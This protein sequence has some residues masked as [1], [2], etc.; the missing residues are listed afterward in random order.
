MNKYKNLIFILL[1]ILVSFLYKL[2]ISIK[3]PPSSIHQWRQ[4]DALSITKNYFEEGMHFFEPK[5]HFQA[6]VEGK[7]VGEFPIIYYVNAAIWKITGENY[8]TVRLLNLSIV[9]LGLFFLFKLCD[10]YLNNLFYSLLIPYLIFSSPLFGYYSNNFL[11]NLPAVC[12]MFIGWYYLYKSTQENGQKSMV[13]ASILLTI[14]ILLRPTLLIGI[15]PIY[16]IVFLELIGVLKEKYLDKK[17]GFILFIPLLI[18][19]GW[20]LFSK[21]YNLKNGSIYFLLTIKPIWDAPNKLEIWNSFTEIVLPEFYHLGFI[22]LFFVM[23]LYIIFNIKKSNIYLIIILVTLF[24][25]LIIFVLLWFQNLNVHDYYLLDFYLIIPVLFV[26][27]FKLLQNVHLPVFNSKI[28]KSGLFVILILSF[29]FGVAKTRIKYFG[30]NTFV[31]KN[32]LSKREHQY[33]EWLKWD[34]ETRIQSAETV[35]PFLRKIGLKRT[36][37][38]LSIPDVSPNITLNFMDQKGYTLLYNDNKTKKEVIENAIENKVKYLIITDKVL[39][40][41]SSISDFTKNKIG[42]Y[43]NVS[44]FK[45]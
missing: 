39:A 27:F 22:L 34:Y 3:Y 8:V 5:I 13:I 7:A 23:F 9:F 29:C 35:T 2:Q 32:F 6:S 1:F 42:E 31:S 30:N 19:I 21:D 41:D 17:K 16:L 36:D 12:L 24:I 26:A 10:R 18:L 28:V 25:E 20:I 14:S 15:V 44:V 40:K 33:W 11:I 38:V 45:L 4:A 37:L 43:K